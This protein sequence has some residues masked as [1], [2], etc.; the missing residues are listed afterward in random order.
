MT[1]NLVHDLIPVE[2]PPDTTSLRS[3]TKKSDASVM[4]RDKLNA[5]LD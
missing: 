5:S 4:G 2:T 3:L 1:Q